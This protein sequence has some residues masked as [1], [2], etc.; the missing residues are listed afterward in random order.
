M[1]IRLRFLVNAGPVKKLALPCTLRGTALS[2]VTQ[3]RCS[4]LV[5]TGPEDRKK[6]G[7]G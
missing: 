1:V 4:L 5:A 6:K 3:G 7:W 2:G